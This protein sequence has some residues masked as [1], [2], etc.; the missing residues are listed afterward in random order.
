MR[1]VNLQGFTFPKV[2]LCSTEDK[3]QRIVNKVCVSNRFRKQWIK[4]N[5]V[6]LFNAQ[7]LKVFNIISFLINKRQI[8][9]IAFAKFI[10]SEKNF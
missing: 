7:L 4:T 6:D 5:H 2:N 8:L 10:W 3:F 1:Y 9:Y